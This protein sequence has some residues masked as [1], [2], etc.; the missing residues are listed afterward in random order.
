M[1]EKCVTGPHERLAKQFSALFV[2]DRCPSAAL[3][4]NANYHLIHKFKCVGKVSHE[5]VSMVVWG[6]S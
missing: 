1:R 4:L 6:C 2:P 5:I 3:R